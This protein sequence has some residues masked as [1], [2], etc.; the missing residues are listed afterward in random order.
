MFLQ[1]CCYYYCFI[2][3]VI[4]YPILL[5]RIARFGLQRPSSVALVHCYLDV[6]HAPYRVAV[7]LIR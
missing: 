6:E 2:F 5:G 3:L 1:E 4:I 7:Y